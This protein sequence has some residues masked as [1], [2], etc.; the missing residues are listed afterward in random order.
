M[1]EWLRDASIALALAVCACPLLPV[2]PLPC[3]QF[4][5]RDRAP[6]GTRKR[7]GLLLHGPRRASAAS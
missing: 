5:A 2:A 1:P 4:F 7:I 6:P 3:F